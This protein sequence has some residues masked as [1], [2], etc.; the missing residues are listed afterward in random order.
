MELKELTTKDL[1]ELDDSQIVELHYK[2]HK[3]WVEEF[4]E[5]DEDEE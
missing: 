1:S 5:E 2:L 3:L 4:I